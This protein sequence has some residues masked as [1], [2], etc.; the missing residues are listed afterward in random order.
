MISPK[1]YYSVPE[2]AKRLLVNEETV[3]RHIRAGRLR[4]ERIGNQWFIRQ[5]DLRIFVAIQNRD[6]V[7][8]RGLTNR[9]KQVALLATQGYSNKE[10]SKILGLTP[11]TVATHIASIFIKLRISRRTQIRESLTGKLIADVK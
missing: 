3:R 10:V 2:F 8:A 9:E 1:D 5:E 11:G 6:I 4:A 7:V